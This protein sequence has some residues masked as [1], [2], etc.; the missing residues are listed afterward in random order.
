MDEKNLEFF[1]EKI[2]PNIPYDER[3]EVELW[4][5]MAMAENYQRGFNRGYEIALEN[6]ISSTVKSQ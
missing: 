3:G 2:M 1:R 4:F 6:A 5:V